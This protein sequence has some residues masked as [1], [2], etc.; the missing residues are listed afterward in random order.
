M[1]AA[2]LCEQ[3]IEA[4][5][6]EPCY[7]GV[8]PGDMAVI[9]FAGNCGT[10]C[11]MAWV[12]AVNL[13]PMIGVGN[14]SETAGNCSAELGAVLEVGIMRCIGTPT[15]P[16]T[17]QEYLEAAELQ[18]RD[19][20]VSRKAIVCCEAFSSKDFI[21]GSYAPVGPQGGYGGGTWQITVI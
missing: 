1:L 7:C 2:C 4:G 14:V 17:A 21:L 13:T 6:P 10:K 18:M 5:L 15:R 8:I 9:D 19:A 12:R 3:I 20:M 11:G 16:P